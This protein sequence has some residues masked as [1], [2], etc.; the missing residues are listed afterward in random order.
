MS[1]L[2]FILLM[3]PTLFLAVG[4]AAAVV[5]FFSDRQRD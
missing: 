1:A 3:A 4:F 5:E 2:I